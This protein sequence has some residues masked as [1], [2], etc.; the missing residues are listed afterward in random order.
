MMLTVYYYSQATKGVG[1]R[2]PAKQS[3]KKDIPLKAP[4]KS[5]VD[6]ATRLSQGLSVAELEK[7][8]S[9]RKKYG[10]IPNNG[11][12]AGFVLDPYGATSGMSYSGKEV[13][14]MTVVQ[15]GESAFDNNINNSHMFNNDNASIASMSM[16]Q[17]NSMPSF[18]QPYQR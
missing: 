13:L 11:Y 10:G 4:T 17:Q 7:R 16:Q 5:Q 14:P 3:D 9:S 6:A 1:W 8:A 2:A 18:G 15:P 12:A